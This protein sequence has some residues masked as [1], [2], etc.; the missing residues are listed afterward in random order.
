MTEAATP[1][2]RAG[3]L[4]AD[5]LRKVQEAAHIPG[6]A[7][8]ADWRED[9]GVIVCVVSFDR[10]DLHRLK[11][12]AEREHL[13]QVRVEEDEQLGAFRAIYSF[14]GSTGEEPILYPA[15][16]MESSVAS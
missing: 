9:L 7:P 6:G 12:T 15:A 13:R 11:G 10:A 2:W 8:F 3:A 14:P 4:W 16:G 1:L 5:A